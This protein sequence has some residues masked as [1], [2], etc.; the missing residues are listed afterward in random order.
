MECLGGSNYAF[1]LLPILEILLSADESII[2]Q[3]AIN[4]LEKIIN[5]TKQEE[6]ILEFIVP[7]IKRLAE[8]DWFS[9]KCSSASLIGFSVSLISKDEERNELFQMLSRLCRDDSASVRRASVQSLSQV[10]KSTN[11]F[12]ATNALLP[13]LQDVSDDIQVRRDCF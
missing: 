3:N 8:G 5:L 11:K 9:R 1:L 12:E 7:M 2:R 13:I 6:F 4:S 10:I